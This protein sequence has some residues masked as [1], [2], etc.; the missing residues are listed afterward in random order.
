MFEHIFYEY[1]KF[2]N[3]FA[4]YLLLGFLIAGFLHTFVNDAFIQDNL[5]G[6]KFVNIVKATLIGIPLP[7]CSC[8]VIPVAM[9]LYKK[10]ASK[11]ATTSFLISTPQTGVDSIMMTYAMFL[12]ILPIFI[13]FRPIAALTAGLL[14]GMLVKFFDDEAKSE[15]KECNHEN[16]SLKDIFTYG[17][18]SL[19]QD[20]AKPLLIGILFASIISKAPENLFSSYISSGGISELLTVLILSIPLYVCATASIPIAVALVATETISPGGALVFLMAGPVTN[21]ATITTI[22]QVLGQRLVSIYLF[23]VSFTAL[24]FG[25]IINQFFE[26]NVTVLNSLNQNIMHHQHS[27]TFE[28][29]SSILMLLILLNAIFRPFQNK[30]KGSDLDTKINVSGMT[31]NHCKQSV[32]ETVLSIQNVTDVN[33]DLN[34]GD[35]FIS[36]ENVNIEEVY[37]SVEKIG[38]KIIK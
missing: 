32:I 8:G 28:Y 27:G 16:K 23:A 20:I 19:P 13:I 5:L 25:Y 10:G 34:S 37:S 22:Y 30:I 31:C 3:Q 7:L 18:I 15:I 33:V 9:S 12:P 36:G 4:P 21:M 35:V 17:F 24:L 29:L 38:F 11:S 6:N 2:L 1:W 26:I 14:G